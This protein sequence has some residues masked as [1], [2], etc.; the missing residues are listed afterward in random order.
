[1]K[2]RILNITNTL[3]TGAVDNWLVCVC[4]RIAAE[5]PHWQWTFYCL[6]ENPGRLE[7]RARGFGARVIRS[8]YRL[9]DKRAF[10]S[11]L[12]AFMKSNP[13]DI[14]HSQ[15]DF[16]SAAYLL[17]G[18]GLPFRKRI[19]HIHNSE[20]GIATPSRWKQLLLRETMRQ[21]CLRL[22]DHIVGVSRDA[23]SKFLRNKPPQPGRDRVLYCGVDTQRFNKPPWD[24]EEFRRS[25]G[26]PA[27]AKVLL[28]VGRMVP[29]KNP[30]FVVDMVQ[31]LAKLDPSV[32]ACFVGTG[33][34]ES[35][36][37]RRVQAMALGNRVRLLGWRDDIPQI[38]RSSDL[39][40]FSNVEEPKEGLGLVL[41]EAQAAGLPVLLSRGA[42][43]D[44]I[45]IPELAQILPLASGTVAWARRA[46]ECLAKPI[47]DRHASLKKV[48]DSPFTLTKSASALTELYQS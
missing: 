2:N 9:G 26:L 14:L 34:L 23:L 12:R 17:A 40:V 43:E 11:S 22:A 16:V 42:P 37:A 13:H 25:L 47:P 32:V 27:G 15:N 20:K 19:V 6:D 36:V 44:A 21:A 5:N 7:E 33:E 38:M 4:E 48:E 10:M 41:V 1:M 18:L 46:A 39:L 28:F 24:R 45:V 31:V 35:Q 3:D 30:L 29:L 8:P